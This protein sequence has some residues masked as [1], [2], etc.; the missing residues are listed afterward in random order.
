MGTTGTMRRRSIDATAVLLLTAVAVALP[1]PGGAEQP[2]GSVVVLTG[3]PRQVVTFR[4]AYG[5][6][7]IT[8]VPIM[9]VP[10][11]SAPGGDPR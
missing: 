7:P 6:L 9:S 10:G 4:P 1:H 2:R 11:T 5:D 8:A 3:D